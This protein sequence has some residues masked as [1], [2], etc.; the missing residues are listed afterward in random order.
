MALSQRP[1]LG[2]RQVYETMTGRCRAEAKS[3]CSS[4]VKFS[5][6]AK[7]NAALEIFPVTSG[8]DAI[9]KNDDVFPTASSSLAPLQKLFPASLLERC[10]VRV[11][12]D[13][14]ELSLLLQTFVLTEY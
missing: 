10:Q 2:V 9:P 14:F 1:A 6:S 5:K 13:A 12:E 7:I 4:W 8:D 3:F 11:Y